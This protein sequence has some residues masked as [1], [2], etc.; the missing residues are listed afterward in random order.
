VYPAVFV[1]HSTTNR[2][3]SAERN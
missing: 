3:P 1:N 2:F